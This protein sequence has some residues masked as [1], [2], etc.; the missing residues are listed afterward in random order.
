MAY[1]A[2]S[3]RHGNEIM[4]VMLCTEQR[5][6]ASHHNLHINCKPAKRETLYGDHDHHHRFDNYANKTHKMAKIDMD[7]IKVI[8]PHPCMGWNVKESVKKWSKDEVNAHST[9]LSSA[10]L[11]R[12]STESEAKLDKESG[13]RPTS[14]MTF[15]SWLS[16]KNEA[17]KQLAEKERRNAETQKERAKQRA[18]LAEAKYE[19]WLSEK[20]RQ[21]QRS[22]SNLN[23]KDLEKRDSLSTA[24]TLSQLG[25]EEDPSHRLYEWE[26]EKLNEM[27]RQREEREERDSFNLIFEQQRRELGEEAW[28]QWVKSSHNKPKPV[29]MGQGLDSLRGTISPHF[30]NPNEWQPLIKDN[31]N[32]GENGQE[33]LKIKQRA[34]PDYSRLDRLAQPKKKLWMQTFGQP[35]KL[36]IKPN[37]SLMNMDRSPSTQAPSKQ[38]K[39]SL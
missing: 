23:C 7:K 4:R 38:S 29:P 16:A 37:G 39:I 31:T 32:E 21:L 27:R 24:S 10:S 34:G 9:L 17:Q 26:Q 35:I 25:P 2:S 15:C 6:V 36:Q 30:V 13:N 8:K 19:N 22:T 14:L 28:L 11:L 20:T 5:T 33:Q 12:P 18:C 3:D 1:V